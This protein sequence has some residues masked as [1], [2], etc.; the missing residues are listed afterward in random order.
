MTEFIFDQLAP[1]F[2]ESVERLLE[3]IDSVLAKIRRGI[4]FVEFEHFELL[5][6]RNNS[7]Q[8]EI[9]WL[10][11]RGVQ[12][13]HFDTCQ[14]IFEEFNELVYEFEVE[15]QMNL[16]QQVFKCQL[17]HQFLVCERCLIVVDYGRLILELLQKLTVNK[18]LSSL[19]SQL[20]FL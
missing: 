13:K 6:F 11:V 15:V 16:R 20:V 7:Q 4:I 12:Q 19:L 8:V 1:V 14:V 3:E 2:S 5:E 9:I 18:H 17:Y 10:E